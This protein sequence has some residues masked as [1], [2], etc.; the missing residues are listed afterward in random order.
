MRK[1][2]FTLIEL[3]VVI[4]IIGILA[5][6]LL[7]ALARAREAAR[8]SSCANNLKQF[9]LVFKMYANESKGEKWP[10][11]VPDTPWGYDGIDFG[12]NC[13]GAE[14]CLDPIPGCIFDQPNVNVWPGWGVWVEQVYPN[15]LTDLNIF[16]CPSSARAQKDIDSSIGIIRDDGSGTCPYPFYVTNHYRFYQYF[17]HVVDQVEINDPTFFETSA[18]GEQIPFCE[19]LQ[20]YMDAL[21]AGG[22]WSGDISISAPGIDAD[23][24]TDQGLGTG[25]GSTFMRLREGIER[26]LIT[27]INNP[28]GS[29][30]GQTEI[31]VMWDY[32]A[33]NTV[34]VMGE[35]WPTG[36]VTL[37]NH[38]PGGANVLYMDGHVEFQTYPGG[39][40]PSHPAA[41]WFLGWG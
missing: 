17:G 5:A 34:Q 38:V 15:Y 12:V 30:K 1:K 29:S 20:A 10:I 37:F 3:L 7:P 13:G 22:K 35:D 36:G 23:L 8:R 28:A 25:G 32:T 41:A 31:H 2:G 33:G 11:Q 21:G 19:A 26:F 39:K 16:V 27:D 6:I 24:E 4:A 14:G 40:F 18:S 9:G